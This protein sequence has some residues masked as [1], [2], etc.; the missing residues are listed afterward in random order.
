MT[1]ED[2]WRRQLAFTS[3]LLATVDKP[4]DQ[5]T[6]DDR[7][8][9]TREYCLYLH[10]EVDEVLDNVPWKQHRFIGNASREDLLE[11]LVDVQKFLFGL[12]QV[13]NVTPAELYRAFMR[14]SDVVEQRFYQDHVLPSQVMNDK[15]AIVDIDDVVADWEQGFVDWAYDVEPDMI[16]ERLMDPGMRSRLKDKIHSEG[17]MLTLPILRDSRAG[18]EALQGEGYVI[19]WLTA[20]PVSK[21]P[22]LRGDT[23]EW[24][25]KNNLSCDYIY[26]SDLN[27]HVFVAEK[28][29]RAA[30]LFDD[31]PEI[32]SNAREIGLYAYQ[33]SNALPFYEAV[34]KF[35]E[36]RSERVE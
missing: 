7:V 29:P 26:Y 34:L 3:H 36:E 32:V 2:M 13:W 12:M 25:K 6:E 33:V 19:V 16:P 23:V 14:K 30:V 28:F 11:E 27:K 10:K 15:V 17:G 18:I 20:R 9:L 8:R 1:I 31:K 24:L 5:L 4:L 21:Y 22:R 35:L